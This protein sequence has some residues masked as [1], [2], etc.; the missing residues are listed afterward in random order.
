MVGLEKRRLLKAIENNEYKRELLKEVYVKI[1]LEA[2]NNDIKIKA[3]IVKFIK[4]L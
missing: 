4:S 1:L 2:I 3:N